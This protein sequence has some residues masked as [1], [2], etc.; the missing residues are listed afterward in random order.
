VIGVAEDNI[1]STPL[2]PLWHRGVLG[3]YRKVSGTYSDIIEEGAN[4]DKL[5]RRAMQDM[6][7][8]LKN[9]AVEQLWKAHKDVY[10]DLGRECWAKAIY[11]QYFESRGINY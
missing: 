7:A 4:I 10:T 1:I 6:G 8:D 11:K 2:T 3:K 5:I 9:P